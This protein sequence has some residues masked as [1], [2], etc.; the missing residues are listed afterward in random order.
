MVHYNFERLG[1]RAFQM[2]CQS[3]VA[4]EFAGVQCMPLGMPDGG[5][6]ITAAGASVVF[7]VKFS[8]S[9]RSVADPVSWLKQ[10]I[11]ADLE[12]LPALHRA[13]ATQ[14]VVITNVRG[15]PHPG[16]GRIDQV[17]AFLDEQCPMPAMC[18]WGDDLDR[19]LDAAFDVKMRYPVLL[20]GVDMMRLMLQHGAGTDTARLD[21]V[22][23]SYLR[24][25][26]AAD[27]M[28][29]F[30]QA[31]DLT[32]PLFDLF[33]DVPVRVA[34][35]DDRARRWDQ[36]TGPET[37]RY[38]QPSAH[39]AARRARLVGAAAALFD[40]ALGAEFPLMVLQGAPG[41]GK[42]TLAQ[43]VAQVQRVRLLNLAEQAAGL[44]VSHLAAPVTLPIKM[45]LRD[46]GVWMS[47]CDP[48][49]GDGLA[50]RQ[51]RTL[52]AVLAGHIAR[53]SGGHRFD[54]SD[55]AG[56]TTAPTL[57]VL[58]ALDEI[59]DLE[60]RDRVV[61]EIHAAAAR[62]TGHGRDVRIL[63][64]SRPSAIPGAPTIDPELFLHLRLAAIPTYTAVRY[65]DKWGR[66][67]GLDKPR[68]QEISGIL[69]ARLSAPHAVDLARN[70]MQLSI[71]LTLI[72]Q[73][74]AQ[75]P[76]RRTELYD[77]YVDLYFDREAD[78]SVTVRDHRDLFI[79]LHRRLG[80]LLHADAEQKGTAGR[81][82]AAQLRT[83]IHEHLAER[84]L[85]AELL[86]DLLIGAAE[87]VFFLVARLEGMYEFEVQPLREY[88]AAQHLYKTTPYRSAGEPGGGG[89][90]DRFAGIAPSPYWMNVT[91]FMAG[92]FQSTELAGLADHLADLIGAAADEP[93]GAF[94]RTL[95]ITLLGDGVFTHNPR[96]AGRLVEAVFDTEGRT[97][98]AI[99]A[100][101]EQRKRSGPVGPVTLPAS[102]A[103]HL[104]DAIWPQITAAGA[105]LDEHTYGLCALLAAQ[106]ATALVADR[107]RQGLVERRGPERDTWFAVGAAA[108][109]LQ[110]LPGPVLADVLG[111]DPQPAQLQAA[112]L[113]MSEIDSLAPDLVWAAT[114]AVLNRAPGRLPERSA[115]TSA[116][117]LLARLVAPA[118]WIN[119]LARNREDNPGAIADLRSA[120]RFVNLTRNSPIMPVLN[121]VARAVGAKLRDPWATH[122]WEALT[123]ALS[124]AFG[125]TLTGVELGVIAAADDPSDTDELPFDID[126][127]FGPDNLPGRVRYARDH[128]TD[129]GWWHRQ[130]QGLRTDTDRFLWLLA[131]TTYA[132]GRVVANLLPQYTQTL[133]DL[134]KD[135]QDAL[136]DAA[137]RTPSYTPNTGDLPL[138]LAA[139]R[140][141][142][143]PAAGLCILAH[144]ISETALLPTILDQLVPR[145]SD[146]ATATAALAI[147]T[148]RPWPTRTKP[149]VLLNA[150]AAC[151]AAGA[152]SDHTINQKAWTRWPNMSADQPWLTEIHTRRHQLPDHYVAALYDNGLINQ[153][154][155]TPRI[156]DIAQQQ[157]W[158]D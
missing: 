108:G 12:H 62:L 142:Q 153:R 84:G 122:G 128:S 32:A 69:Q 93:V 17:Q 65:A 101:T 4:K 44:P 83:V 118:T 140:A 5:R 150:A 107:W 123:Q 61:T 50:H 105:H 94:L 10:T 156:L 91:R 151:R 98:A 109:V 60:L 90:H 67:S 143:L 157:H 92:C 113:G 28:V 9:A 110:S 37:E 85:P 25:Q 16:V 76:E 2:L 43:Y 131:L 81:I 11:K 132:S 45:D 70:A 80:F 78:K 38:R 82:S 135:T 3:L 158:F 75:L 77:K 68:I 130:A 1:D 55:L 20:D 7:Q 147:I 48:W 148:G 89:L 59:G 41:Q 126:D 66:A 99:T 125:P 95:S 58:D 86:D 39:P 104:V 21:T 14:Y 96:A 111:P 18:W 114:A 8:D 56:I 116:P 46:V 19:R 74:G 29:R 30:R 57:I 13:G 36:L 47:G 138:D 141:A 73:R 79:D 35:D 136:V 26:Y 24:D 134:P 124:E 54:V 15:T 97:W 72:R 106:P 152:I 144:R 40:P 146:P 33:I 127:L 51:P 34:D 149:A 88:F 137:Q 103:G 115:S 71:L 133:T 139:L 119:L 154:Y 53:F 155:T 102:A 42:S 120:H 112:C 22:I 52:E 121:G 129:L 100:Q 27:R 145:L 49:D 23:Q 63:V 117:V 64:T 31:D 87:R 6:D